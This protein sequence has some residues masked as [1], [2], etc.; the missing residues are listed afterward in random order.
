MS[1]AIVILVLLATP[2]W[3]YQLHVRADD[4]D[5]MTQVDPSSPELNIDT[6]LDFDA[7]GIRA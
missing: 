3:A 4:P 1:V 7:D 6:V 5:H 2:A